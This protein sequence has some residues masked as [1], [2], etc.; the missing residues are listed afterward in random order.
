MRK[1]LLAIAIILSSYQV[2][3]Q[4][5]WQDDGPLGDPWP[6]LTA[7]ECAD[8]GKEHGYPECGAPRRRKPPKSFRW[9]AERIKPGAATLGAT[10]SLLSDC[11]TK[12]DV[13]FAQCRKTSDE[14]ECNAQCS[15]DTVCGMKIRL[16]HGQFIDAQIEGAQWKPPVKAAGK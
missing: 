9:A 8:Y 1:A 11:A 6:R 7:S 4:D 13:C 14:P 12:M 5:G 15:T 16:T 2:S 3:A 10:S